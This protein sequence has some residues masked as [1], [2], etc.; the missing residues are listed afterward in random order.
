M[1]MLDYAMDAM[2]AGLC[3]LPPKEDGSKAPFEPWKKYQ[4]QQPTPAKLREWF[5]K[6]KLEGMGY[7]TGKISDNLEVMD[8]DIADAWPRYV[9]ALADGDVD[10]LSTMENGLVETTPKGV[11]LYYRCAEIEKNKKLAMENGKVMIETRGE[12][13]YIVAAPSNGKVNPAG[14]YEIISGSLATIPTISRKQ[15]AFLHQ[16]ASVVFDQSEAKPAPVITPVIK[17]EQT[18]ERP[19]DDYNAKHTV[20]EVLLKHGW[21]CVGNRGDIEHWRKPNS[22]KNGHHATVNHDGSGRFYCFSSEALPF[23]PE[24]SYSA[25]S[26]FVLLEHGGDYKKAAGELAKSGYGDGLPT[27]TAA[28]QSPKNEAVKK[29]GGV[30]VAELMSMN[31]P[32]IRWIVEGLIP[33]GCIVLAGSPKIGKSWLATDMIMSITTEGRKLF[34]HFKCPTG[35]ALYLALEDSHARLQSRIKTICDGLLPYHPQ[36]AKPND[37]AHIHIEW[38]II[39]KGCMEDMEEFVALNP[40]TRL[41]I[42]DT[43]QRVRPIGGA[44]GANAYEVDYAVVSQFQQFAIKHHLAII[45]ITHLRKSNGLGDEDPFEQVTGSMGISG[46]AD[47]T[48][49]LK[50]GKQSDIAELYIRGRDVEEQALTLKS[51]G[52]VWFYQGQD[53]EAP[54]HLDEIR[55]CMQELNKPYIAPSD[56]GRWYRAN[57]GK[58][59]QHVRTMFKRLYDGG[60]LRKSGEGKYYV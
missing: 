38:P 56:F 42:V 27:E 29:T 26:C 60:H 24:T 14:H 7:V 8:F 36:A 21:E 39:G 25:F 18:G 52:G 17:S 23:E 34:G 47:A 50:R 59:L 28:W 30:N 43:L 9:A 4:S 40:D 35:S 3:V 57:F 16:L 13:G 20:Q 44:K 53:A 41:I 15:R 1:N 46:A 10:L 58:E 31:L 54:A 2:K 33:E 12:G 48:I 19:G 22:S 5:N 11:H 51:V 49:R 55:E 45:L 6:H 32:P 37:K